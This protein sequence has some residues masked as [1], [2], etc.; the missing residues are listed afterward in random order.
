[1]LVGEISFEIFM[2]K[3]IKGRVIVEIQVIILRVGSNKDEEG[4]DEIKESSCRVF[5][6]ELYIQFFFFVIFDFII[7]YYLLDFFYYVYFY[8]L[9]ISGKKY[10]D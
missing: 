9:I 2:L 3:M 6:E 7:K 5:D 1:M 8:F 10:F 4:K